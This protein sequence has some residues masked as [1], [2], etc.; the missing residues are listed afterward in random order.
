[1][2]FLIIKLVIFSCYALTVLSN[3]II[4]INYTILKINIT[5]TLFKKK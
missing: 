3:V 2:C 4:I 5:K 1:M